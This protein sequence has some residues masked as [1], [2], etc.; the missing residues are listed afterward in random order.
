M[1][2]ALYGNIC[3]N[4]YTLAKT[5]RQKMNIDAHLYL[6][7]KVD[8]QNKPES[9][10]PELKDNYPDW[11]HVSDQWD[12]LPFLKKWDKTF[13]R[14]LNKYDIVFLSDL[15]VVFIPFLKG[16]TFFYVTGSDLTQVPF[17][18]KFASKFKTIKD[19]L[20]W[21][22]IGYMQRRGI[23]HATKIFTQPFFPFANALKELHINGSQISKSY[24]P[25]LM[26]MNIINTNDNAWNEIDEHNKKLLE[27]FKFIIFH[28][29]RIVLRKTKELVD[30]GHWKGNDNLFKALAL[31]I[32]KYNAHDICIAMPDRIYSADR[33]MAKEIIKDL[34]IEK[35][36]VWLKPPTE[37]GFPR[38][39]LMNFYSVADIV[40]DEF[41]TGWFGSIVVEGMA[42]SK[43]TFCYVDETV[44][45][46]LYPS[47]PIISV[48]EPQ[49]IAE[50]IALFYF[51][52][53]KAKEQ[54]ELS[55]KWALEFHSVKEGTNIYINNFKKELKDIFN[56]D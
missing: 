28:P 10:D 8:I 14:E 18:K 36:I 41:A 7:D 1:K 45:K 52:K 21:E 46:Q 32:K 37:E 47:H 15:G 48:K 38:K 17:P 29:S 39:E 9:D 49:D 30:S 31:F 27:P 26:D 19:R 24:F 34:G 25:I 42:C 11:I 12:T 16:K 35:N 13:I 56:L 51:N 5:F 50:Q 22:Y 4:F 55:R 6:N 53:E 3:N 23:R 40:A 33:N 43:P 20:A 2:I 54:G 44:M